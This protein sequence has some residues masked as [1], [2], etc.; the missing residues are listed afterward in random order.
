M[1]AVP[2]EPQSQIP[3][4]PAGTRRALR[5]LRIVLSAAGGLLFGLAIGGAVAVLIATQFFGW[6]ILTVQTGSMSP[7]LNPGDLVISRPGEIADIKEGDI[8]LY[9]NTKDHVQVV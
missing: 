1:V 7:A 8:V 4:L 2:A 9:E 3:T 5:W 6:K